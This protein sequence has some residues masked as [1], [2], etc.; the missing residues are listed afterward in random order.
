MRGLGKEFLLLLLTLF[1]AMIF[2]SCKD[3]EF[4]DYAASW[5]SDHA[6]NN[7]RDLSSR[8]LDYY[9]NSLHLAKLE[10]MEKVVTGTELI[11]GNLYNILTAENKEIE[12]GL[13]GLRALELKKINE[14]NIITLLNIK[15]K[16][17]QLKS[18]LQNLENVCKKDHFDKKNLKV[19]A[20]NEL[21]QV[22]GG[23]SQLNK[24]S[25]PDS[26]FITSDIERMVVAMYSNLSSL[27][28]D[29]KFDRQMARLNGAVEVIKEKIDKSEPIFLESSRRFCEDK[30][31]QLGPIYQKY[32]QLWQEFEKLQGILYQT[33]LHRQ[34]FLK[35]I[36]AKEKRTMLD[37]M[38]GDVIKN[39]EEKLAKEK[40][41][42]EVAKEFT[43]WREY[44]MGM[45]QAF[46]SD[47]NRQKRIDLF[48]KMTVHNK[49]IESI[50]TRME[51]EEKNHPLKDILE[52]EKKN[53]EDFY[54]RMRLYKT[55]I[56][57]KSC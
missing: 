23:I 24:L 55:V 29:R 6:D 57:K 7:I 50:V 19:F 54:G 25:S 26:Y 41:I 43:Q 48:T 20:I 1:T 14:A 53:I 11:L 2:S 10:S 56:E 32:H 49:A 44:L 30:K 38:M 13:K 5:V 16:L 40:V 45:H 36:I 47:C 12:I 34:T 31:T 51:K 21:F 33:S 4:G 27:F 8:N 37:Q 22:A 35:N 18:E 46:I 17:D 9:W 3:Q 52:M 39:Y 28:K 42:T 15:F